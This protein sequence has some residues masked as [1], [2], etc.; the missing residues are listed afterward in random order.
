MRMSRILR[1]N[2]IRFDYDRRS[3]WEKRLERVAEAASLQVGPNAERNRSRV[4]AAFGLLLMVGLV[5]WAVGGW[6]GWWR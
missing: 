4:T 5:V 1:E 2:Q 6:A 3:A